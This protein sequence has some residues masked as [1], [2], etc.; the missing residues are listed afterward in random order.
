VHLAQT[1]KPRIT[2]GWAAD[3]EG[4]MGLRRGPIPAV[5]CYRTNAEVG[6][7][8]E[9]DMVHQFA[10]ETENYDAYVN[11]APATEICS[12]CKAPGHNEEQCKKKMREETCGFCSKRGHDFT[13]CFAL[14]NGLKDGRYKKTTMDRQFKSQGDNTAPLEP[15]KA[16]DTQYQGTPGESHRFEQRNWNGNGRGRG[17]GRF[18]RGGYRRPQERT[19]QN[20]PQESL[21]L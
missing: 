17:R 8:P 4:R 13:Q 5:N 7:M 14:I 12:H 11:M 18:Q 1:L 9:E 10:Y 6:P 16:A 20:T 3:H 21:N 15:S 19:E 2:G